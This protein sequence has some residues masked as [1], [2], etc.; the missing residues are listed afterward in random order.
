MTGAH[1]IGEMLRA[2]SQ[3]TEKVVMASI[4]AGILPDGV[5]LPA[6]L[7]RLV[8]SIDAQPLK[9]GATV[10]I[11]DRIAV[12]V[13]ASSYAEQVEIIK[14]VKKA[15]A[16]KAGTF[17]DL[18]SIAILTD[19]TGPDVLGPGNSFEQTQDFRVSYDAPT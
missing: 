11:R 18:S 7:V 17:A 9:R 5:T 6:L 12:T 13:R 19:S 16:G 15:C 4:K 2:D 1:I 14:R 3:V 8:S 10:R